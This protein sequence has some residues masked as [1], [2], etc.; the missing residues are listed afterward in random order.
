MKEVLVK[1]VSKQG[2]E[3]RRLTVERG[4][5]MEWDSRISEGDERIRAYAERPRA[6]SCVDAER[7]EH[8][9]LLETLPCSGPHFIYHCV[10]FVECL[11]TK[12]RVVMNTFAEGELLLVGHFLPL[13]PEHRR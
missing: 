5:V 13:L 12:R 1:I 8:L 2:C 9:V 11:L 3:T 7:T 6:C 4:L 10:A